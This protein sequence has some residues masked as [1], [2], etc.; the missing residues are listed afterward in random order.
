VLHNNSLL[1]RNYEVSS[2]FSTCRYVRWFNK[3]HRRE[4]DNREWV[5]VHLLCGVNTMSESGKRGLPAPGGCG[6]CGT[7]LWRSASNSAKRVFSS[8][9]VVL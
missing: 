4:T 6:G 2:G 9:W 1:H 5:K 7:V 3:K 8:L